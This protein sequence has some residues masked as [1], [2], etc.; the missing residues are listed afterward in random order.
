MLSYYFKIAF[1][2]L[3]KHKGFSAL[4]ITGLSIG[5]AIV[6]LLSLYVWDE[7][8]FDRFHSKSDRIYRAWAKE[9]FR[10]NVFF[11]TVTPIILGQE[12]SDNFPEV[13]QV[14]RYYTVNTL[15]KKGNFSELEK[16]QTV[17]PSFFKVFDFKFLRGKPENAFP[18][19]NSVLVTEEIG[20][21][22]FGDPYPM[23]QI[24][25]LQTAG[26]WTHFT[27]TGVLEKA[28]GNSSIQYGI[29]IPFEQGKATLSKEALTSWT[30][31]IVETYI[32]LNEANN[33][34]ELEAKFAPL[35]D[36]RVAAD[37][38]PGEYLVGFQ[39]LT[40]IHLNKDFP[41]GIAPVSDRRYPY[42]LGGIALLI[43]GLA[44]I[45][46]TTL[47]VG[48]SV[49]RAKEVGVRKATGATRGQL[50]AQFWNE[51]VL[52]A[53]LSVGL[54][55]ILS[56][57]ALPF[58][59]HLSDK[60]L[61]MDF[62]PKTGFLLAGLALVTGLVSGVYPALV[63]SGFK[64]ALTLRGL[65]TKIGSDRH[66]VLR[67]LVGFQF[68]LSV[69]LIISTLVMLRQMNFLQNKNLGYDKEQIVV[70]PYSRSGA[71]LT[72]QWNEG[73]QVLDLLRQELNGKPGIN[74]L[75]LS[76]HTF[77]TPGWMKMGYTDP[78][79][80]KFRNFMLNGL[81]DRFLPMY[82]M[83]LAS[84]RNFSRENTSD[85]KAVIVNEAYAQQ[86]GVETGQQM[87]EPFR[88]FQV[89]GVA[90]DFNFESLHTAVQPLVM[91]LDPI[92][93]IQTASDWNFDDVPTPKISIKVSGD[94]LPATLSTLRL[95][96]Q[97]VAPEQAFN[98]AFLD[99]NIDKLYRA[100]SRLSQVVSM[101][102]GLAIFIACLGL[103]GIATLSI[104][105][106]TKEI[107]VRKV[108]GA[109][110]A[111]ITGLLAKDFM[112]IV[113]VS[114][115][116]ASPIAWWAMNAWLDDFAYR[117]DLQWWIFALAGIGAVVIAFLTVGFQSVR[118]ARANPVRSLRSE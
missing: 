54:G 106:R 88:D 65:I 67:G 99:D 60:Q 39:P 59:N 16:V 28:P 45:N 75:A 96:W 76:A 57:L 43:L 84:G 93:I 118:A 5:T 18:D 14:A 74:E 79:T 10:G 116:L 69:L 80:Q 58:F 51:A 115:V 13:E 72:E 6:I 42:I 78:A 26:A 29:V 105:Q 32:L 73:K 15:A 8:T 37:Y 98:Y 40:D 112:K 53:G 12:L 41:L 21:K 83:E 56:Q 35:V 19:I 89:I 44:C 71:R 81:D 38:K 85:Q 2:S 108:L 48:R 22:Y 111:G 102:A 4:N 36:S 103:F 87:P 97:K 86:F 34:K 49:A 11:N 101:A 61:A 33:V 24:L 107:G 31:V 9:H 52:T 114:F 94:Q 27:V 63:L 17:E 30:N 66:T 70:L 64:P 109:S 91:A 23:G 95:A 92:G 55:V 7:W 20:R 1:R 46:F 110:V 47:S 50:M 117:V 3:W 77:G 90:K 82:N 113:L 25:T 62:S 104:A 68:L 100:E